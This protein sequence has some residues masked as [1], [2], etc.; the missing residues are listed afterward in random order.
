MKCLAFRTLS[1]LLWLAHFPLSFLSQ[2][3]SLLAFRLVTPPSV[4]PSLWLTATHFTLFLITPQ[5]LN[6]HAE[7]YFKA[8]LSTLTKD[9]EQCLS[10]V[11]SW[12]CE[13]KGQSLILL[14]EDFLAQC[15]TQDSAFVFGYAACV[16]LNIA[17]KLFVSDVWSC[18][19]INLFFWVCVS[20]CM[21][22][23]LWSAHTCCEPSWEK[24]LIRLVACRKNSR[25][26]YSAN[27]KKQGSQVCHTLT[28]CSA[29]LTILCTH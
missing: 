9:P 19:L 4:V 13:L 29:H 16:I 12:E 1:N 10:S 2:P 21:C 26:I 18:T 7:N 8:S 25:S 27:S 23:C 3:A 22:S 5:P 24:W 11:I 15:V 6:W 20:K 17:A 28:Q 14:L